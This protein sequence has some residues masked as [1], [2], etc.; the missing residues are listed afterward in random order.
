MF[1]SRADLGASHARRS[2]VP[3]PAARKEEGRSYQCRVRRA[4][5]WAEI[6]SALSLWQYIVMIHPA[7]VHTLSG[8]AVT[9]LVLEILE[10][11]GVNA[12]RQVVSQLLWEVRD[13]ALR[14]TAT[15]ADV[16]ID[17]LRA[18]GVPVDPGAW[19]DDDA[20]AAV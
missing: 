3:P 17:R 12:Q 8:A 11:Q 2:Y 13:G 6:D 14:R 10:V 1:N 18:K 16:T 19:E 9:E 4:R 7:R 5:Y 20:G 15:T